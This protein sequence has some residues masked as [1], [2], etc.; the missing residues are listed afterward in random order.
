MAFNAFQRLLDATP[1][2]HV[3]HVQTL[4]EK[5]ASLRAL[6][7]ADVKAFHSAFYGAGDATFAAVGDFDPK[8]VKAQVATPVRRLER[9][10]AVRAHPGHHQE[11][12]RR[13]DR[14]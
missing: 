3:K 11:R 1:E 5:L 13:K 9:G 14:A 7:V 10:A 12:Q 2:G 8:E 6:K 4:P